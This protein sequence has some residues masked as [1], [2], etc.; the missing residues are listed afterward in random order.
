MKPSHEI[1]EEL[2]RGSVDEM[3]RLVIY[4]LTEEPIEDWRRESLDSVRENT[5][6]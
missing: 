5:V 1:L 6:V 2:K 4:M 3:S